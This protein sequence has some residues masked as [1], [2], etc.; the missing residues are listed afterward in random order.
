MNRPQQIH[1]LSPYSNWSFVLFQT[2]AISCPT[3]PYLHIAPN[4]SD[5]CCYKH[6]GFLVLGQEKMPVQA[7]TCML[8]DDYL[9]YLYSIAVG[10]PDVCRT[11][12]SSSMSLR[13]LSTDNQGFRGS[14]FVFGSHT[15]KDDARQGI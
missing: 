1:L 12:Q 8:W 15:L 11:F 5:L 6:E 4:T 14:D 13:R 10:L 2:I 7:P 3:N 9:R